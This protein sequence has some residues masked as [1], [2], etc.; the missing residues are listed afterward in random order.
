MELKS[1]CT[2]GLWV[3]ERHEGKCWCHQ[4]LNRTPSLCQL[5]VAALHFQFLVRTHRSSCVPLRFPPDVRPDPHSLGSHLP[6]VS[7]D[8]SI[9]ASSSMS[10]F[11]LGP[12]CGSMVGLVYQCGHFIT[13]LLFLGHVL[14]LAWEGGLWMFSSFMRLK[15][16]EIEER[17]V[18]QS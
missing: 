15:L 13:R 9:T 1:L 12:Q 14:V 2:F 17:R 4:V 18:T 16:Q 3:F 8:R 5:L 11:R 10:G 7:L 6:G